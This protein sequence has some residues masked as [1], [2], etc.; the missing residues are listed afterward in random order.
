V[1]TQKLTF[2]PAYYYEFGI[3]GNALKCQINSAGLSLKYSQISLFISIY[4][5]PVGIVTQREF[6]I[7]NFHLAKNHYLTELPG[8]TYIYL[9]ELIYAS[10]L[11]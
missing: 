8:I 7:E 4:Q 11:S 1:L 9:Y 6:A 3:I 5:T 10:C 2:S